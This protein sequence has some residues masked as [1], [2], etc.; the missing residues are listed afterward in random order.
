MKTDDLISMLSTNLEPVKS[1]RVVLA[2]IGSLA[3]GAAIAICLMMGMF[4]TPVAAFRGD[5][6]VR[7]MLTLAFTL[8][9]VGGGVRFLVKS[10]RP[11]QSGRKPLLFIGLV[12]LA[13]LLA[14]CAV[15][16][17]SAPASWGALILG[18]QWSTC[19]LCIPLFAIA[20]FAALVWAMRKGAPTHLVRSGAVTGL[21]AG[22][23]G[24]TVFAIQY[25]SAS[26]PFVV[27]WYGGLIVLCAA[28]GAL[29]GSRLLRW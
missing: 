16:L 29:L 21:V 20:P 1:E 28:V 9:L 25:P 2:L 27:F 6:A 26:I 4:G 24:A 5:H 17:T 11:G 8:G 22:A 15:L 10:A 12:F 7:Q 23:S 13:Y 18:P 3:I 14:A 19:L